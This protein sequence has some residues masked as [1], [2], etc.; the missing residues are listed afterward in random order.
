MPGENNFESVLLDALENISEAFVIYDKEGYLVTCNENFR[1]L[2]NYSMSEAA[3]GIHY[4]DLGKLD[5]ARGHVVV[6]DEDVTVEVLERVPLVSSVS[7][8]VESTFSSAAS[9][10]SS[11]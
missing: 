11:S 4:H 3:P 1:K 7:L 10:R 9:A 5:V 2:Y 6:G 8:V